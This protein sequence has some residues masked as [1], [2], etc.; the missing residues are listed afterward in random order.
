MVEAFCILVYLY[1][2]IMNLQ[3]YFFLIYYFHGRGLLYTSI[4]V[5]FYNELSTKLFIYHEKVEAVVYLY[6]GILF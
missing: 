4:F 6:S 5:Y 2:S 1:I 3:P